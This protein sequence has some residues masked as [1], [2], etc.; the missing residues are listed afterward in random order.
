VIPAESG[1]IVAGKIGI[2]QWLVNRI[3]TRAVKEGAPLTPLQIQQFDSDAMSKEQCRKFK[4]EFEKENEWLQ[5]FNRT[6]CLLRNAIAED[7]AN[8]PAARSRYDT[9][10]HELE[11]RHESFTLWA[12]CV[13]AI[14][15]YKSRHK[16]HSWD[17][18]MTLI[19]LAVILCIILF[20]LKVL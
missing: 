5:F 2:H 19:I 16:R 7:A 9:M 18:V 1:A 10:V 13:P 15:G 4:K 14:P 17:V 3:V 20:K 8:D 11:D 6:G 12:C